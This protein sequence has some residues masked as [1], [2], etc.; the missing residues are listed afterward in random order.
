MVQPS[1][2]AGPPKRARRPRPVAAIT[3]ASV[4]VPLTIPPPGPRTPARSSASTLTSVAVITA[5]TRAA[6]SGSASTTMIA[7]MVD[8]AHTATGSTPAATGLPRPTVITARARMPWACASPTAACSV[9][10]EVRRPTRGAGTPDRSAKRATAP[11]GSAQGSFLTTWRLTIARA[12]P[13]PPPHTADESTRSLV[14]LDTTT[15]PRPISTAMPGITRRPRSEPRA[16]PEQEVGAERG[17]P[18][19]LRVALV[20]HVHH[21]EVSV[22]RIQEPPLPDQAVGATDVHARPA[23]VEDVAEVV[24]LLGAEVDLREQRQ[25]ADRLPRQPDVQ[26]VLGHARQGIARVQVLRLGVGVVDVAHEVVPEVDL[27]GELE[28]LRAGPPDVGHLHEREDVRRHRL[29]H[30]LEVDVEVGGAKA[31]AVLPD[32]LLDA[33]VP[34]DAL[35]G[36]QVGVGEAREEQVVEGR[37]AESRAGAAPQPRARLADHQRDR[38]P[39][40]RRAAEGAVVLVAEARAR[41]EPVE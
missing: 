8:G 31:D 4:E 23:A 38:A 25:L 1:S 35:L 16:Q 12:S 3:T 41:V 32:L 7:L 30:V 13:S 27:G 36:L 20:R 19:H 6:G 28:A 21:A 33:G 24:E 14:S 39:A 26:H 11:S 29:D 17:E 15:A 2:L 37:R 10:A 34:R 9:P 22:E 5:F 18:A 40:G